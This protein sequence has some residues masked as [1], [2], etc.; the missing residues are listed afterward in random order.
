MKGFCVLRFFHSNAVSY[1][2]INWQ[3]LV[4][5]KFI[6]A[7][8]AP[9]ACRDTVKIS[10]R[11]LQ[12]N[13]AANIEH[14]WKS[15]GMYTLLLPWTLCAAIRCALNCSHRVLQTQPSSFCREWCPTSPPTPN[16][17]VVIQ[18]C[19]FNF[20]KQH[21][22]TIS[23]LHFQPNQLQHWWQ[24][25]KN[26][27]IT[28][29]LILCRMVA[30]FKNPALLVRHAQITPPENILEPQMWM[31]PHKLNWKTRQQS[32]GSP[33]VLSYFGTA[34][35]S[36]IQCFGQIVS[37]K[38]CTSGYPAYWNK[39]EWYDETGWNRASGLSS[40]KFARVCQ[41]MSSNRQSQGRKWF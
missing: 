39:P 13:L 4:I 30:S 23:W 17:K 22:T 6:T 28:C 11:R 41:S 15:P 29:D 14:V 27:R 31:W 35:N 18:I 5:D 1:Q 16:F 34:M 7:P 3:N 2:E 21:K 10:Q 19:C 38:V 32:K 40:S 24:E 36:K 8:F 12:V 37:I 25:G 20:K 33:C 9:T 26:L